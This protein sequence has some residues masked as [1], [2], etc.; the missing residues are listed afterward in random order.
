MPQ[1]IFPLN[2]LSLDTHS[3][4]GD[5]PYIW[6]RLPLP[7]LS[8]ADAV[9]IDSW[10]VNTEEPLFAKVSMVAS[11]TKTR[12]SFI[13]ELDPSAQTFLQVS[14]ITDPT[15]SFAINYVFSSLKFYSLYTKVKA[16]WPMVG[17]TA[18]TCK[19]NM[20]DPR[21]LDA[22]FR[23]TFVGSPTITANG[24]DWDGATQY[25]DTHLNPSLVLTANNSSMAYYSRESDATTIYDMGAQTLAT[26][27]QRMLL[28]I[29]FG[30]QTSVAYYDNS[31]S[32]LGP[33][34]TDG[35]GLYIPSRTAANALATYKNGAVQASSAGAA[36]T[37]PNAPI[38]IGAVSNG[39][40][41]LNF[42]KLQCAGASVHDGLIASEVQTMTSIY[43][44]FNLIL[45][46]AIAM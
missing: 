37:Q 39:T 44:T 34:N 8:P 1:H 25:A 33:A 42:G 15:I 13:L 36:G 7:E 16:F 41:V 4:L 27:A 40:G 26:T 30:G 45:G 11:G 31:T 24:I 43:Q 18:A 20:V 9:T 29:Q 2:R 38:L 28:G 23:L 17:G 46:R 19:W 3:L 12:A 14:G 32:G 10:F 5:P 22:A 6:G 21:D 35:K